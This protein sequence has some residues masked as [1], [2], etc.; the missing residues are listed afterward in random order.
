MGCRVVTS[1]GMSDGDLEKAGQPKWTGEKDS[2]Y[3]KT[4]NSGP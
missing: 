3:A 4:L 2:N 1:D